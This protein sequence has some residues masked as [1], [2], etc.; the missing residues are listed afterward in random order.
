MRPKIIR[1]AGVCSTLV[2]VIATSWPMLR[3]ALL[4]HDHRAVVQVADALADLVARLDQPDRHGLAGQG[5]RLQGVGQLVEVDDLDALQLGDLVQVE[6]VGH[7][8]GAERLGQDHQPLVHLVRRRAAPAGWPRASA[9]R[10][11]GCSASA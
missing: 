10:S 7:H 11:W 3:P 9:A 2:T 6:V 8:P 4:D 1:P 5:H